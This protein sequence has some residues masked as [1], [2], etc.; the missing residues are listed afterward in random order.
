MDWRKPKINKAIDDSMFEGSIMR[1]RYL[2]TFVAVIALF[3]FT[4]YA[5]ATP[6]QLT[7]FGIP[8]DQNFNTLAMSGTSSTLPN[9][10]AMSTATYTADTGSSTTGG[11]K[12]YGSTGSSERAL[13]SLAS[14]TT[15]TLFYGAEFQN[16]TGGIIDSL[17]II[18]TGEQWRRGANTPQ[19][20]ET[21]FFEYSL[22][23]TSVIDGLATWTGVSTLDFTSPNATTTSASALNGNLGANKTALG[24]TINGSLM[25]ANNAT[26][27]I[28]Y[29]DPDNSG[30]D[31]GL[32][33]DDFSLTP[34]GIIPEPSSAILLAVG[35][36]AFALA[37]WRKRTAR[38]SVHIT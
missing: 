22:N 26:F 29:R 8:Y 36:M 18:Y 2:L 6:I 32:A 27:W 4:G 31:H 24:D 5:Q 3:A 16:K 21:L 11:M 14:G 37:Y 9:G 25:I 34:Q 19:R 23:A 17:D 15:G 12:S 20:A 38:K 10:W 28:R 7:A 13:G 1:I 35:V 30:N 33:V